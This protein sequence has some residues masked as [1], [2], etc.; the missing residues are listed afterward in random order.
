MDKEIEVPDI[1][2][3]VKSLIESKVIS[4]LK[5]NSPAHKAGLREGQKIIA[6]C[7]HLGKPNLTI[8]IGIEEEGKYKEISFKPEKIKK[9]IPQYVKFNPSYLYRG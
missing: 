2:F 6:Y 9:I 5:L 3:D 7:I 4:N 1:G 8:N